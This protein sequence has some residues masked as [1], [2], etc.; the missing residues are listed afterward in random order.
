MFS[1]IQNQK[2]SSMTVLKK[3]S[4][5][6]L[7]LC[8]LS[9]CGPTLSPFTQRLQEENEWSENELKRIQFYLSHDII[10]RRQIT[11][12]ASEIIR[13]EIKVLDGKKVEEIL[14]RRNTPGV[15]VYNPK[16]NR[17]GV[18][19][20]ADRDDLYLMFGPN[21]K[22]GGRY[23]LLASEWKRRRGT[24]SYSGKKWYVDGDNALASL[25]VDLKKTRRLSVDSR[26]ARGRRID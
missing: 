10:L 22:S 12:G 1:K 2:K 16:E 13:G 25:L 15:L 21:P 17:F 3:I 8:M 19:F 23:T 24:V 7:M 4:L 11:E 6:A 9:A 18:S 26:V 5:A 14:I 20:E